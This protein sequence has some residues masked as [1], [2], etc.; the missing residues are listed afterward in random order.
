MKTAALPVDHLHGVKRHVHV[1]QHGEVLGDLAALHQL[2]Q[3]LDGHQR[4][5]LHQVRELGWGQADVI[6]QLRVL[7]QLRQQ[8]QERHIISINFLNKSRNNSCEKFKWLLHD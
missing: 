4:V 3:H 1:D 8:L 2:Q 5:V 7:L 6:D